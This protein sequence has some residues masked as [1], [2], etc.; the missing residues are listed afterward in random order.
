[1]DTIQQYNKALVAIAMGVVTIANSIWPGSVGIQESTI[2]VIIAAV[3]PVLVYL[4][5][6]KVKQ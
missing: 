1:M 5:P 3:T 2:N 4:I 6:N